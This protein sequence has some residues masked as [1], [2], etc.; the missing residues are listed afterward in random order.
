MSAPAAVLTLARLE[1]RDALESEQPQLGVDA[2]RRR[3]PA[4]AAT[5][6]DH[7]VARNDEREGVVAHRPPHRLR[8]ADHA[9][10]AGE[11]AVGRGDATWNSTR[12]GVHP[13]VELRDAA[14]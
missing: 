14:E 1:E 6:S 2:A 4:V 10:T 13:L 9:D 12:G 11:L 8:R 7:A 5:G 3:E